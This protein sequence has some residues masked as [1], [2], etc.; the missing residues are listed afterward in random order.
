[1]PGG[2]ALLVGV[3]GSGKQS[4][5]KLASFICGYSVYQIS[6]TS[7]YGVADLKEELKELYKKAGV[8]PAEPMVFMMTD[9]QIVDERFLV[10][11]ND[12]LSSGVIP[13]LFLKD[14]YDAIFSSLKWNEI[15]FSQPFSLLTS[16][17]ITPRPAGGNLGDAY[18]VLQTKGPYSK[19][20]YCPVYSH[21]DSRLVSKSALVDGEGENFKEENKSDGT[22]APRLSKATE[23]EIRARI[24]T[25]P[26]CCS[27]LTKAQYTRRYA[28][29]RI[30]NFVI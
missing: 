21:R 6:V 25:R 29:S 5:A 17:S 18:Y 1:M 8:K 27:E 23:I 26:S 24:R 15:K 22:H 7:D 13:D 30:K 14:E 20:I 9:S 11:V 3:G 12:L 16:V 2:N 10:Y 28:P 4:L 19:T